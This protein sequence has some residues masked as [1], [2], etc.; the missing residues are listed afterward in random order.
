MMY[1]SMGA[2]ER[3]LL[4]FE[5][6]DHDLA[7]QEEMQPYLKHFATAFFGYYLRGQEDYA[8]Y[9]T[10]ESAEQIPGL[11]LEVYEGE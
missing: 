4:T 7:L 2:D 8:A 10:V 1:Q 3:Y 11:A 9:L 5:G 6:V